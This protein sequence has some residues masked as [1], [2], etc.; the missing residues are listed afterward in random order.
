MLYIVVAVMDVGI[1]DNEALLT[2]GIML[3]QNVSKC[4][5]VPLVGRLWC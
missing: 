5:F 2:T 4:A 1:M 3:I